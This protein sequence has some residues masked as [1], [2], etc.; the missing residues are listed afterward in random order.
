MI[1]QL[2]IGLILDCGSRSAA[3][4]ACDVSCVDLIWQ[5]LSCCT[6]LACTWCS[7]QCH[8]AQQAAYQ[9]E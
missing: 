2:Q 9:G 5:L 6:S 3:A 8:L 1:T 7:W 4:A